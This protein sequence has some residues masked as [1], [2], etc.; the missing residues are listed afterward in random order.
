VNTCINWD[1]NMLHPETTWDP[2]SQCVPI[3]ISE[4]TCKNAHI[5]AYP[6]EAALEPLSY[7]EGAILLPLPL[8]DTDVMYSSLHY[9]LKGDTTS[10]F[11]PPHTNPQG[12]PLSLNSSIFTTFQWC[13][14]TPKFIPKSPYDSLNNPI[15]NYVQMTN[16][17]LTGYIFPPQE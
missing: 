15:C 1:E 11:W 10:H 3:L 17:H 5:F 8:Y 2:Q 9:D 14:S 6:P 13:W 4:T 12:F 16:T 7:G